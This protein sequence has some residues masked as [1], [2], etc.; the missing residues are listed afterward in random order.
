MNIRAATFEYTSYNIVGPR[1]LL[2]SP[3][4]VEFRLS[5][6]FQQDPE[7]IQST[8]YDT[9]TTRGTTT[10]G[11]DK[12]TVASRGME[13]NRAYVKNINEHIGID[14]DHLY[15]LRHSPVEDPPYNFT[16][17]KV[18]KL[19]PTIQRS[20]H[21]VKETNSEDAEDDDD[22]TE[23]SSQH[24]DISSRCSLSG[25][26]QYSQMKTQNEKQETMHSNNENRAVLSRDPQGG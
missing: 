19:I 23:A 25:R 3:L 16:C 11:N 15:H 21:E 7:Q 1:L 18:D 9:R 5:S 20:T 14:S 24:Q 26:A 17:K 10:E 6:R 4:S 13:R 8:Q 22:D 2:I 12:S